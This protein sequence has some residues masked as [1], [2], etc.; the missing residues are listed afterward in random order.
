MAPDDPGTARAVFCV[1]RARAT[2]PGL[3]DM[4][5]VPGGPSDQ[6]GRVSGRRSCAEVAGRAE[7]Y[8]VAL[9]ASARAAGR[10]VWSCLCLLEVTASGLTCY[11]ELP[12]GTDFAPNL[13]DGLPDSTKATWVTVPIAGWAN[14]SFQGTR[15]KSVEY[16]VRVGTKCVYQQWNETFSE[17]EDEK[18]VIVN[19]A[20][21]ELHV[22]LVRGR[23]QR[24][25]VR[26]G[27]LLNTTLGQ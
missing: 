1:N 22:P 18:V 4:G 11:G 7:D 16:C 6:N 2:A 19:M 24:A 10:P 23:L 15:R 26:L 3:A 9:G 8:L 17:G 21:L 27:H 13:L 14:E 5:P 25:G 20:Y 12:A